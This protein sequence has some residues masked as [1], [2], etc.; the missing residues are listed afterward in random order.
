MSEVPLERPQSKRPWIDD[1]SDISLA[2]P[3]GLMIVLAQTLSALTPCLALG[4]SQRALGLM[5]PGPLPSASASGD[6]NPC[7]VT[8]V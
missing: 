3:A 2:L 1:Q 5:L 7:K 8:P 6:T 4:L